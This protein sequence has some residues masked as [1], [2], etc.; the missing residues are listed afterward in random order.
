[1][2]ADSDEHDEEGRITEDLDGVRNSMVEKRMKKAALIKEAALEPV[3]TGAKD[4]SRL[5]VSWGSNFNAIEEALSIVNDPKTAFVH[6]PQV[7]PLPKS[8][9][10]IL[11]QAKEIIDIEQNET[12]QFADLI[13][14]ET[15]IDI[16]KRVLKYNGMPFSVE[17]IVK[18]L[19]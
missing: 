8:T 18:V 3:I 17:E 7:Y 9:A 4:Y 16:K 1:V 11:A 12:G 2:C 19:K 5:I 10:E 14:L 13:K 6:F 15:G